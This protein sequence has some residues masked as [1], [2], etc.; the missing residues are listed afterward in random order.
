MFLLVALGTEAQITL[1][2]SVKLFFNEVA[3]CAAKDV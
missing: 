1:V 2:W 3:R